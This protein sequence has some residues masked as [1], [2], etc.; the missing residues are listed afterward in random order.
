M[1]CSRELASGK[2]CN[3]Q[4]HTH[5]AQDATVRQLIDK[6]PKGIP[7]KERAQLGTAI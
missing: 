2:R 5:K 6:V 4:P 7:D 3:L 1:A